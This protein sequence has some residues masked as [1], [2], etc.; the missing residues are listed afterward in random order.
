[1][2]IFPSELQWG[3]HLHPTTIIP[4]DKI[5]LYTDSCPQG[6]GGTY[7]SHHFLGQ[8]P[9]SWQSYNIAVLE[10]YPILIALHLFEEDMANK[11]LLIHTDNHAVADVLQS[12]TSKHHQLLALLRHI[13]LHCLN[14][15]IRISSKHISGITNIIPDALSRNTHTSVL[16]QAA[17]IDVHPTPIPRHLLPENYKW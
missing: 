7:K 10:L 11:H 12:K 15:N 6:F 14:Y 13:V 4:S 1:M 2:V 3:H 16:L 8:F 5:N 17:K 9:P